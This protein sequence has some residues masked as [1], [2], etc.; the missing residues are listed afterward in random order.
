MREG[1]QFWERL[2]E[3]AGMSAES[4]SRR[5]V[6]E[7]AGENRV[8]IENHR[9]VTAYGQE[10]IA[11]KTKFGS[12]RVC[13]CGLTVM[14]LTKDQLVICGRIKTVSLHRRG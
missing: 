3:E 10:E 11:V 1:R 4:V 14:H 5:C 12:V 7:I 13:G 9:G 6:V 8:L 2:A